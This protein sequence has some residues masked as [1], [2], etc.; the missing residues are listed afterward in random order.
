MFTKANNFYA[1]DFIKFLA[2]TEQAVQLISKLKSL[3]AADG[4]KLTKWPTNTLSILK[5]IPIEE[6]SSMCIMQ[7]YITPR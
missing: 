2:T 5:A 3:Q 6:R 4:L 1:D 7:G